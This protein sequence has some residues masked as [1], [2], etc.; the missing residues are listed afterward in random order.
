MQDISQLSRLPTELIVKITEEL[1]CKDILRFM[2]VSKRMYLICIKH[3]DWMSISYKLWGT[4][5][6]EK[7]NIKY[8]YVNFIIDMSAKEF[9]TRRYLLKNEIH[10]IIYFKPSRHVYR[11]IEKILPDNG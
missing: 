7:G 3:L 8:S 11:I 10:S 1:D 9:M 5:R 2:R 6:S 4:S